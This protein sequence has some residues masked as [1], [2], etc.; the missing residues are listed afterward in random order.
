VPIDNPLL[1]AL[2][3]HADDG[4]APTDVSATLVITNA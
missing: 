2:N 3:W 1:G 4:S